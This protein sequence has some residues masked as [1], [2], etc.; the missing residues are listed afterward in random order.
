MRLSRKRQR[1]LELALSRSERDAFEAAID[2]LTELLT[3][4]ARRTGIDLFGGSPDAAA[5]MVE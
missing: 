1:S 2:R 4:E 5:D 3:E